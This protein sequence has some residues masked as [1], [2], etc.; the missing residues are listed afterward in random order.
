LPGQRLVV[1]SNGLLARAKA[2]CPGVHPPG[3]IGLQ[4][5]TG[6]VQLRQVRVRRF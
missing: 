2:T 4:Y 6:K 5:H 1:R 3:V